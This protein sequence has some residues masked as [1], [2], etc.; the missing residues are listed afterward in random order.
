MY[1]VAAIARL[2]RLPWNFFLLI[3][4]FLCY[5]EYFFGKILALDLGRRKKKVKTNCSTESAHLFQPNL[6]S[7][8]CAPMGPSAER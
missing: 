3:S 4:E 5:F 6:M 1:Y 8:L 7:A 2:G